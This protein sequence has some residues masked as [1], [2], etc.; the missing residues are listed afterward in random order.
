[1]S[2][3]E[4]DLHG[5]KVT[6]IYARLEVNEHQDV[7]AEHMPVILHLPHA[8]VLDLGEGGDEAEVA[9][10]LTAQEARALAMHLLEAAQAAEGR[11]A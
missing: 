9:L 2:L 11:A 3:Y 6:D 4:A 7:D 1:M 10:N 8:I 5:E